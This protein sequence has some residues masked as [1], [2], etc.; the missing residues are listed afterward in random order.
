MIYNTL[1]LVITFDDIFNMLSLMQTVLSVH[2]LITFNVL[3]LQTVHYE[4][5]VS[6]C[7]ISD[8]YFVWFSDCV[9]TSV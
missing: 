1:L 7:L 9:H 3:Y 6:R 2:R 4:R 8:A 5:C